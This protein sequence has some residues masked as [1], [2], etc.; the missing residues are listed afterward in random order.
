VL[1]HRNQA[2]SSVTDVH[3]CPIVVGGAGG[4]G[5]TISYSYF[6]FG[7]VR[8][9]SGST[10]NPFK[11]VGR[12]GYYDDPSTDFQYV[13]ARYYAPAYAR[14]LTVD[15]RLGLRPDQ[16]ATA[17][18]GYEQPYAYVGNAPVLIADPSGLLSKR[19]CKRS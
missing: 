7:D 2:L 12:L 3:A 11:F 15:P 9:S 17:T 10:T 14:F 19:A 5:K 8:T 13:R 4:R 1:G 18:T 6:A 16:A